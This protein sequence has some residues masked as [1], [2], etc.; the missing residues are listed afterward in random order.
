MEERPCNSPD[1][2]SSRL[3]CEKENKQ[4]TLGFYCFQLKITKTHAL[5]NDTTQGAC[6]TSCARGPMPG[7]RD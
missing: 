4:K 6:G 3:C 5:G 1:L 7:L 2:P